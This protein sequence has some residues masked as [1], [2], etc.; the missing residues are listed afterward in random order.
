MEDTTLVQMASFPALA[1][2]A[3][4]FPSLQH[5]PMPILEMRSAPT[6]I[7]TLSRLTVRGDLCEVG[8]CPSHFIRFSGRF[9][10]HLIAEGS[11]T[12]P[13]SRQSFQLAP[14]LRIHT[15]LAAYWYPGSQ[16]Y[17]SSRRR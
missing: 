14:R 4:S 1:A 3:F 9:L 5:L 8:A 15:L 13:R 6:T 16:T 10:F 17:L 11:F 7:S 2:Q 12:L